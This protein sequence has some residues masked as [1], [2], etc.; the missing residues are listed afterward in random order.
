MRP[1]TLHTHLR[2]AL[3][4]CDLPADLTW[5]QCTRH[6][7]ASQ[8]VMADGSIEK[9]AAE[10]GHSSTV[11]TERYSHLKPEHFREKDRKIL[12]VDLDHAGAEVVPLSKDGA[13]GPRIAHEAVGSTVEKGDYTSTI[14]DLRR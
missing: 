10:L 5:Y 2:E 6:T 8:W 13:L 12:D 14:N 1:H 3:K 9:L 11:V 7:F 4:D